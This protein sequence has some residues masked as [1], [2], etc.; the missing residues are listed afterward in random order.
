MPV[1]MDGVARKSLLK[2]KICLQSSALGVNDLITC[3]LTCKIAL[4][5]FHC[6]L[7]S[8]AQREQL[9]PEG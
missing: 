1:I 2:V 7:S 5:H 3:L 8:L 6:T 4:E 9:S